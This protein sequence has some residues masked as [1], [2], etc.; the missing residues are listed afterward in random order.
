MDYDRIIGNSVYWV[1]RLFFS[2]EDNSEIDLETGEGF[3]NGVLNRNIGPAKEGDFVSLS[4]VRDQVTVSIWDEN[5]EL[6]EIYSFRAVL[7]PPVIHA[8]RK[9]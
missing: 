2:E 9:L 3:T 5:D 6:Q 7:Q 8:G 4:N 1:V